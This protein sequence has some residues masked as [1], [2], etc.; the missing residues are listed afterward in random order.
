MEWIPEE[1]VAEDGSVRKAVAKQRQSVLSF[2]CAF[3]TKRFRHIR[4]IF[5]DSKQFGIFSDS[6]KGIDFVRKIQYTTIALKKRI[7][8]AAGSGAVW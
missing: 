8:Q 1:Q 6:E 5:R 7:Y 4:G 3:L 2:F